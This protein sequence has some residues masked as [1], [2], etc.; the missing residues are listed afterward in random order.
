[1]SAWLSIVI[2]S[3]IAVV[4]LLASK[5]YPKI[6]PNYIFTVLLILTVGSA[7]FGIIRYSNEQRN[8]DAKWNFQ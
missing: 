8:I 5:F 2:P 3:A 4:T 7:V 6:M 1:M